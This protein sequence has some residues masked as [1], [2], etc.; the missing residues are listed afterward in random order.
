MK[1]TAIWFAIVNVAL[2]LLDILLSDPASRAD[3]F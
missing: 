3:T 2:L 1:A